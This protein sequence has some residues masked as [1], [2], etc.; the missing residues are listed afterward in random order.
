MISLC[1]S[2]WGCSNR[3]HTLGALNNRILCPL[4]SEVGSWS[5]PAGWPLLRIPFL[6]VAD[7]SLHPHGVFPV[8]TRVLSS[9]SCEDSGHTG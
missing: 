3:E 7:L 2:S 8:C 1:V 9:P 6:Q 5:Y 4:S